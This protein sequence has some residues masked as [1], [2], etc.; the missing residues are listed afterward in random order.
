[1]SHD[2]KHLVAN[3]SSNSIL[4]AFFLNASFAIIEFVGSYYT[5]SIAIQS[6]ALHDFGDSL[7][8]LFSYFAEKFS[9]KESDEKFTHGYRRFSLLAGFVNGVILLGGSIY[10]LIDSIQRLQHPEAVYAPGMIGLAIVGI[11][12]NSY[13]ALRLNKNS[14]LNSKMIS[15]HLL[16]DVLSWVAVLIVSIILMFR[17]WFIL[18][19]ILSIMISLLILKGVYK[20]LMSIGS[21]FLQK[22]PDGLVIKDIRNEIMKLPHVEDVHLIKGWAIDESKFNISLH[23]RVNLDTSIAQLD[24]LRRKVEEYLEKKDVLE[25]TIQ[26]EGS[27]C[28]Y[29][30]KTIG[31]VHD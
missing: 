20:N 3:K 25:L 23:V 14:G 11:I 4:V 10:V 24:L 5:N 22:F 13:A 28:S 8:L 15:L 16:E 26:F 31:A 29:S 6:D 18:D 2:H 12:V 9:L 19:S 21:I 7:A 1:M 30:A 27:D 17:P